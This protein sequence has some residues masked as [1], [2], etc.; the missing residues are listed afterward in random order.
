MWGLEI[1]PVWLYLFNLKKKEFYLQAFSPPFVPF[2]WKQSCYFYWAGYLAECAEGHKEFIQTLAQGMNQA[3]L[4]DRAQRP[5]KNLVQ[6]QKTQMPSRVGRSWKWGSLIFHQSLLQARRRLCFQAQKFPNALETRTFKNIAGWAPHFQG[7][8]NKE[9][10]PGRG[11][12]RGHLAAKLSP[13]RL[14]LSQ[15]RVLLLAVL[16]LLQV[17][18]PCAIPQKHTLGQCVPCWPEHIFSPLCF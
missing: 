2:I 15:S 1:S 8:I 13:N 4:R 12:V 9:M 3:R 16:L 17:R 11:S 18:I 14:P 6:R 5:W 7:L 10:G